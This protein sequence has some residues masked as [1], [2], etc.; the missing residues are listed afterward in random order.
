MTIIGRWQGFALPSATAAVVSL[1]VVGVIYML[2][3]PGRPRR[4]AKVVGFA[5]VTVAAPRGSTS[6]WTTCSTCSPASPS[7]WPSR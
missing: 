7:V 2:V 4:I 3:L 5:V 6:A 1:T